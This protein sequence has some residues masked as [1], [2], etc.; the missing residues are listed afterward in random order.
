MKICHS[1]CHISLKPA[2]KNYQRY[3]LRGANT[4]KNTFEFGIPNKKS[5]LFHKWND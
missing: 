2:R 5:S 4:K 3:L 1:T